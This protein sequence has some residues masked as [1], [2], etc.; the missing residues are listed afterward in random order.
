MG[1]VGTGRGERELEGLRGNG[2][3][4]DV[5]GAQQR[6]ER[7][8]LAQ[9][10]GH[11]ASRG[12]TARERLVRRGAPFQIPAAGQATEEDGSRE[13]GGED[14]IGRAIWIVAIGSGLDWGRDVFG[15]PSHGGSPG[16]VLTRRG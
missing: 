4:G 2:A 6:G 11:V 12:A 10:E 15:R 16:D 5:P 8:S 1:E 7:S 3:V 13:V 9:V 14:A